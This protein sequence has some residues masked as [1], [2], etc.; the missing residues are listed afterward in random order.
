MNYSQTR[1]EAPRL[2]LIATTEGRGETYL[3]AM[4]QIVYFAL[5]ERLR[6]KMCALH[7]LLG[8]N[9]ATWNSILRK[10]VSFTLAPF[11][12]GSTTTVSFM[13]HACKF[14]R[15]ISMHNWSDGLDVVF[16]GDTLTAPCCMIGFVMSFVGDQ[17]SSLIGSTSRFTDGS[18]MTRE[19]PVRFCEQLGVKLPRLTHF[20]P[21]C[22][23]RK[24]PRDGARRMAEEAIYLRDSLLFYEEQ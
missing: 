18:R 14:W 8:W 13:H 3:G 5:V 23:Q 6:Q 1:I 17:S 9:P 21:S 2:A 15:S 16:D 10:R 24:S 19:C 4:V 20:C 7:R 12:V 22:D 11:V